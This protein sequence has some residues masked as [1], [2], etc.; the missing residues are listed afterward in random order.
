MKLAKVSKVLILQIRMTFIL[1]NSRFVLFGIGVNF[2]DLTSKWWLVLLL[3]S[4]DYL[5]KFDKPMDL[6]SP[7]STS[8]SMASQVS[9]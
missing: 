9:R 7:S 6:Q 1:K 8:A 3:V 2:F 5:L 4:V